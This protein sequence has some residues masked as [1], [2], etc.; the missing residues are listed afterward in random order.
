MHKLIEDFRYR[1]EVDGLRA[2]AVL[3][4]VFYHA[5]LGFSGGFIG[6][7]VFFVIS[8]YLITSLILKDLQN[9]RF[10]LGHFWERRIRRIMPA[11]AV[12][13]L[14]VLV[15]GWFLLLPEDYDDLGAS[16]LSQSVFSANI[17]FWRTLDYFASAAEEKPL[18]HTWSLAV[19]EQFYLIFPFFLLLL[20]RLKFLHT[21]KSLF[22]VF[23]VGALLS[24]AISV[25]SLQASP[26]A[27]FYLLPS[28]AWEL[29]LGSV[30][31][32]APHPPDLKQHN[33][34]YGLLSWVGVVAILVPSFTYTSETPFPGMAALPPVLGTAAFIW[35]T[36]RPDAVGLTASARVLLA[37]KPVVFV[38]LISYSLYLWHWPLLAFARYVNVVALP[39]GFRLGLILLAFALAILSWR[40]VETPFRRRREG[41]SRWWVFA[42]GIACLVGLSVLSAAIIARAGFPQRVDPEILKIASIRSERPEMEEIGPR[43]VKSGEVKVLGQGAGGGVKLLL[44]GDSHGWAVCPGVERFCRENGIEGR[45]IYYPATPPLVDY[46]NRSN[47]GLDARAP[48]WAKEVI[49]Y[50]RK[51]AI[52]HVLVVGYWSKQSKISPPGQLEHAIRETV[53]RLHDAGAHVYLMLQVPSHDVP[54]PDAMAR[55]LFFGQKNTDWR[56]TKADYEA[57]H[58][59]VRRAVADLPKDQVTIIDPE[60]VFFEKES[61]RYRAQSNGHVL[62]YDSHH[63]SPYGAETFLYPTLQAALAPVLQP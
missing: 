31:A 49:E 56:A 29:L 7:D 33:G 36:N 34:L 1:P 41:I 60:P 28:R 14:S 15:A 43:E 4:V 17:Y 26:L 16:A 3:A 20:F 23:T 61:G 53:R 12:V 42:A 25:W 2:I 63:L 11:A 54:V 5:G 58:E 27:S 46:V 51:N 32:L 21:R 39:L 35:A 38:G 48:E 37:A 18:L 10:T 8:G 19:E 44:W 24:F 52:K 40:L 62:F 59:R 13:V 6:V 47:Q 45:A 55:N 57:V 22:V 50:V 30:V 9:G